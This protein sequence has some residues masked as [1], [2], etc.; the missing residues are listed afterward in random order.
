MPVD[1]K[2]FAA[3]KEQMELRNRRAERAQ[4]V[5]EQ[6]NSQL[7]EE[8][9]CKS[10]EQAETLHASLVQDEQKTEQALIQALEQFKVDYS[11]LVK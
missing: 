2:E 11:D 6:L 5:L 7:K 10:L 9:G 1:L 8:F 3:L 4:G